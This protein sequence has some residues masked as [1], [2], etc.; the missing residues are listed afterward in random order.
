MKGRIIFD[1]LMQRTQLKAVDATSLK[2][3]KE[4]IV[5]LFSNLGEVGIEEGDVSFFQVT[6][7]I[8]LQ[9]VCAGGGLN[10]KEEKF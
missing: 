1:A 7:K 5:K 10:V 9:G 4:S 2:G 8:G 6:V 3:G